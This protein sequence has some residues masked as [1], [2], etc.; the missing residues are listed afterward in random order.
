MAEDSYLSA[1]TMQLEVEI[2]LQEAPLANIDANGRAG[3]KL[4]Q[5]LS[6]FVRRL[7]ALYK[8]AC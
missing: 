6:P 7:A 8:D 4:I 3:R 5:R 2:R 1:F